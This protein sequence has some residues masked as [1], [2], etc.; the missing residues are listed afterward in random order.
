M[1]HHIFSERVIGIADPR[2]E[3]QARRFQRGG[4]QHD[5][6]AAHLA[7]LASEPIDIGNAG[8]LA[9]FDYYVACDRIG[10]QCQAAGLIRVRNRG[11]G[12]L[13]YEN[14]IQPCSQG[15]Q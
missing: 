13:K 4:A 7:R 8:C 10:E 11:P 5:N 15:P 2:I 9:I 6:L 1:V 3:Q 14:V 12:L